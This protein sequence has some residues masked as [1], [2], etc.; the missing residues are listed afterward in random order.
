MVWP[1]KALHVLQ[2]KTRRLKPVLAKKR[3]ERG[4]GIIWLTWRKE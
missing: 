1:D 3:K 4:T 2:S